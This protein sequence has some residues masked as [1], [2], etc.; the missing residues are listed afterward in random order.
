MNANAYR[1][2]QLLAENYTDIIRRHSNVND[3]F[4]L[5]DVLSDTVY[6]TLVAD[7]C[8]TGDTT[9]TVYVGVREHGTVMIYNPRLT[10]SKIIRRMVQYDTACDTHHAWYSIRYVPGHDWSDFT[11]V[12][13]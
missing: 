11:P 6:F 1:A 2:A 10:L 7:E 4:I 3:S 12:T 9:A 8:E 13:F 5:R